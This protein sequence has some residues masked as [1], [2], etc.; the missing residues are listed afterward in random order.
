MIPPED[1]PTTAIFSHARTDVGRVREHNEDNFLVDRNLG[2][3]VVADGMGGHASGEVASA[4]AV[5]GLREALKKDADFVEDFISGDKSVRP[6][7]IKNMLEAAM[8]AANIA[9]YQEAKADP[10]KRGMGT[11][12][13]ALMVL[14]GHGFIAHVGDSRV[15]MVRAGEVRMLTEDHSVLN[16]LKRRG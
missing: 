2:L 9:V 3:F 4:V 5:H 16:E 1:M 13:S 10:E 6:E 12:A 11:T 14:G 8:H 7:D 15:Y